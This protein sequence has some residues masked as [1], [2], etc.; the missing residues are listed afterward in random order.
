MD[1]IVKPAAT[2]TFV[3]YASVF[4]ITAGIHA[5]IHQCDKFCTSVLIGYAGGIFGWLGGFLASPYDK[6]EEKRISRISAQ[7]S[8]VISGYFLAK[9]EPSVSRIF[10]QGNVVNDPLY[11]VRVLSFLINMIC[12]A[13]TVYLYRLYGDG[14]PADGSV[15]GASSSAANQPAKKPETPNASQA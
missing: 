13:I 9:L 14:G 15:P 3:T 6:I 2:A 1:R 10:E 12:T 11:G 7:V 5:S 4:V 8:L